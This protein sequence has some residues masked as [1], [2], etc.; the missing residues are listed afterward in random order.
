MSQFTVPCT[1]YRG[2]TSR[3]IFF[4]KEDLPE[5][6]ALRDW[7]FLTGIDSY[8]PSQVDGLGGASSST[9]KVCVI[10]PPTVEGADADWTFFQMGLAN[11]V[12]DEKGTCGNLMAAAGAFAIDEGLVTAAPGAKE[13]EVFLYNTNIKKIL[14]LVVPVTAD[15]VTEETGNFKLAGLVR[16]SAKLTVSIMDPGGEITGSFLPMGKES[17]IEK[18]GKAYTIT[19]ADLINPFVF[20]DGRQFGLTGTEMSGDVA[21]NAALMDLMNGVRD[22]AAVQSGISKDI[23][24]AKYKKPNI[25]KFAMLAPAQDYMTL[26]GKMVK[27]E[28]VDILTKV[29]SSR[30]LHRTSPASGLYNL[31][32]AC[33]VKGTVPNQIAGFSGEETERIV[34]IGH[35][36][37]VVE[38][39]VQLK[40]DKETPAAVG[41]ER[42]ARRIM[43]GDLYVPIKEGN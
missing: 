35:P 37:G 19:F 16:D 11:P 22:I 34:R 43:K 28:D 24:E 8:N 39:V 20:A 2:G 42:S 14:R 38:V 29:I 33:M 36:D 12:V 30:K 21:G 31:A 26:S 32:C 17:V 3:G 13:Q 9:S 10:G 5:D 27:K 15:G 7:I 41:M 4:K 6:T 25:P 18:D 23:E 1:V 40:E